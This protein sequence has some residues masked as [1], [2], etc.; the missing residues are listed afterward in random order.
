M[1]TISLRVPEELLREIDKYARQL[2]ISRA[3]YIR[4]A[5]E[6]CNA[7][8]LEKQRYERIMRASRRVRGES[9]KINAEFD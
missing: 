1:P 3:E 5:L 9:M 8:L 6:E 7:R 2:S 4:R